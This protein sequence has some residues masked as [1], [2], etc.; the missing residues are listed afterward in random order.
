MRKSLK[1]FS[2]LITFFLETNRRVC[3]FIC[4]EGFN[5]EHPS[6]PFKGRGTRLNCKCPRKV[7]Q[8]NKLKIFEFFKNNPKNIQKSRIPP[9]LAHG[10]KRRPTSERAT[11]T[12]PVKMLL[13]WSKLIFVSCVSAELIHEKLSKVTSALFIV[14]KINAWEKIKNFSF[15]IS[16]KLDSANNCWNNQDQN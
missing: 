12:S 9:E 15:F 5:I 1:S 6:R 10:T 7:C 8:E 11:L 16:I 14:L 4:P 2:F 13:W 3:S